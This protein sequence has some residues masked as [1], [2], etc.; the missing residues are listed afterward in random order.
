MPMD[1]S[2]I[3]HDPILPHNKVNPKG[4]GYGVNQGTYGPIEEA[5]PLAAYDA[6]NGS[7]LAINSEDEGLK[8]GWAP[9]VSSDQTP[10]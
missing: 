2:S 7:G 1:Y 10:A 6:F 8:R 3:P 5:N 4:H 9:N